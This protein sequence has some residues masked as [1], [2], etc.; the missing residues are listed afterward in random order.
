YIASRIITAEKL[1]WKAMLLAATTLPDMVFAWWV[2]LATT[3]GV[4][5]HL[6]RIQGQ[7]GEVRREEVN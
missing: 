2:S 5:K 3:I 7:W 4:F 1:G 6:A